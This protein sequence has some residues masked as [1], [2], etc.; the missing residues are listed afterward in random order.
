MIIEN[1]NNLYTAKNIN[2]YL[3]TTIIATNAVFGVVVECY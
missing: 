3:N 1:N 2:T